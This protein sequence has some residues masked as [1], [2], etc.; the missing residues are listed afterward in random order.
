M[1]EVQYYWLTFWLISNR[2]GEVV[3][4]GVVVPL[5]ITV[6]EVLSYLEL[7]RVVEVSERI[8][9]LQFISAMDDV[10]ITLMREKLK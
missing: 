10:F 3:D 5:S 1:P 6:A 2:R 7:V 4:E 9:I 8:K